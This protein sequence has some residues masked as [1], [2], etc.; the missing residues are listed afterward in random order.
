MVTPGPRT[1]PP[2]VVRSK[3]V[4]ELASELVAMRGW[5]DLQ[6]RITL[7]PQGPGEWQTTLFGSDSADAMYEVAS[8]AVQL[9]IVNPAAVLG[10]AI[11]GTGP[12]EEPLPLR[13]ITTIGSFDQLAIGIHERTGI[14]SLDELREKRYPLKISVRGQR[15][16]TVHSINE[17]V[18]Q[19]A[20]FSGDEF[21]SWGGEF[22]YQDGTPYPHRVGSV[23]K[24]EVDAIFD[25]AVNQWMNPGREIGMNIL[26]LS[27]PVLQKLEAQGLRRGTIQKALYPKLSADIE[28]IDYSGF[29]LYTREDTPDETVRAICAAIDARKDRIPQDQGLGPL[30]LDRMCQDTPEGPLFAPLHQAA[31]AYWREH[32]YL[33]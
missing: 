26:P 30:P 20:G 25:E 3:M 13:T 5:R 1:Y 15:D 29:V 14:H 22:V 21:K 10:L 17:M 4:L 28:T 16:H 31:E 24:G 27:E 19:A 23:E 8:G 12:F 9:A 32:G 33:A 7:R 18:M 11:K 6:A 2:V